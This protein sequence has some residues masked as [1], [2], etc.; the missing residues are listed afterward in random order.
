MSAKSTTGGETFEP[1]DYAKKAY[2]LMKTSLD[3]Y[4]PHTVLI[5]RQRYRSGGGAAVQEWT[6]RVNM[7]ESM[8]HAVLHTLSQTSS[9]L[10]MPFFSASN[11]PEFEVYSVSP[12]KVTQLWVQ[13]EG[14][15]TARE[16]K[17]KK[18][19]MA[20]SIVEGEEVKVE[21]MGQ[22]K[23]V[24]ERFNAR[25]QGKAD[26]LADSMLQGLGWWRWHV[27]REEM[28]K[29]IL[30]W[31]DVVK[32]VKEKKIK[33]GKDDVEPKTRRRKLKKEEPE[34]ENAAMDDLTIQSIDIPIQVSASEV[35]LSLPPRKSKSS[36]RKA[37]KSRPKEVIEMH[38]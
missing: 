8:F 21:F 27:N 33:K 31:E 12:K 35:V 18:I 36:T 26:D 38:V 3:M 9:S 11:L 30:S 28:V 5:E 29:E 22:A 14:R 6:V 25:G 4:R 37:S 2:E 20:K 13:E 32:E 1:S 23:E 15:L 17:V 10:S 24:A 7:L 34:K 16:T 19:A